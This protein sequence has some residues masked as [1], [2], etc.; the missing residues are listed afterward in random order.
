MSPLLR[1]LPTLVLVSAGCLLN[2][3]CTALT[4]SAQTAA[5]IHEK[6]GVF[7]GLPAEAQS[8]ILGG[9]IELGYTGDMVYL[10]LGRPKRVLRSADGQRSMWTYVEYFDLAPMTTT[11]MNGPFT[12]RYTPERTAGNMPRATVNYFSSTQAPGFTQYISDPLS[13]S[14]TIY[15]FF[16]QDRVVGIKAEPKL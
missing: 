3:G 8:N 15:V 16:A 12:S 14:K 5:R 4:P 6:P 10:A 13:D 2:A 11:S 1:H 7:E 9:A